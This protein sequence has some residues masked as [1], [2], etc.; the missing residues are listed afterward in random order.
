MK[1]DSD[2]LAVEAGFNGIAYPADGIVDYARQ[3]EF[4]LSACKCRT[5][6]E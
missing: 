6:P 1:M 5:K 4:K 2:R 3:R